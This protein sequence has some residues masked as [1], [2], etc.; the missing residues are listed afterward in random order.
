MKASGSLVSRG[1][2][3]AMSAQLAPLCPRWRSSGSGM[4]LGRRPGSQGTQRFGQQ[5]PRGPSIARVTMSIKC[6]TWPAALLGLCVPPESSVRNQSKRRKP[7][8]LWVLL[9]KCSEICFPWITPYANKQYSEQHPRFSMT[10]DW[11]SRQAGRRDHREAVWLLLNNLCVYCWLQAVICWMGTRWMGV[12]GSVCLF[13]F[14]C[15]W[16][17]YLE[18][19]VCVFARRGK[20]LFSFLCVCAWN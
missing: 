19:C 5:D 14:V 2:G 11:Y 16:D 12:D 8:V 13:V 15:W 17:W 1:R 9:F 18:V 7:S 6:Q 10:R 3:G 20:W 4:E